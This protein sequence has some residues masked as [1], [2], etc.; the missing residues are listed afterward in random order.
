MI[1]T[2]LDASRRTPLQRVRIV[3]H[4]ELVDHARDRRSILLAL[5]YPLLGPILLSVLLHVSAS[6]LGADTVQRLAQGEGP[7]L[8]VAAVGI[9]HAPGLIRFLNDRRIAV[10]PAPS[11]PV[12]A[13]RSGR[14]AVILVIPPEAST[15]D[16]FAIEVIADSGRVATNAPLTAI[17]TAIAAYSRSLGEQR[18]R[19]VGIDPAIL[20]PVEIRNVTVGRTSNVAYFFYNMI[21]PLTVFMVFLGAVYLAIDTTAGER[22]RGSLEPLLTAPVHRWE[23]LFG[24]TLAAF[25]FTAATVA[26]NL[27]SFYILLGAVTANHEGLAAPPGIETMATMFVVG[28]PLMALA[29]TIQIAIAMLTRNM[30][31]AQIYLGLLP[32][33]PAIPAMGLAFAPLHLTAELASVPVLGQLTLFATLAA[34]RAVEP[35]H[36]A[37]SAVTTGIVAF[38]VF[39]AAVGLFQRERQFFAG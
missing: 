32:V 19:D 38:L 35:T 36:I 34:G 27:G 25:V 9:E 6:T 33:L 24:K 1:G 30:K 2:G 20:N 16:R 28:L 17:R 26:I 18:L 11:D 21:P 13:V 15:A 14:E 39:R 29:V 3:F 10:H 7:G 31:E 4:K 37:L 23:L 5:I 12:E 8:S 22:E